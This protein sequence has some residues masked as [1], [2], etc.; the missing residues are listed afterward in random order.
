MKKIVVGISG[1]SGMPLAIRLLKI[2]KNISDVETHLV[3]T[4]GGEMTLLQETS[5][6]IKEVCLLADVVYDYHNIGASIASGTFQVDGMIVIPCSMKTV[7]GIAHGYS[8]NLLLRACDVMIKEQRKLILVA[9][10]TPLSPIHLDNLA[11][12]SKLSHVMI[13]PPVLTYYHLPQT[14]EDMEIHCIGKLLSPFGIEVNHFQR[15][16]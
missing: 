15:W 10:E 3:I 5:M 11:Y 8:D 6:S 9:R 14:I 16:K 7:A 2:L 4:K 12:L 1:A 13:M